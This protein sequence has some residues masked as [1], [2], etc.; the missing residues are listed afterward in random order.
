MP[1]RRQ[2]EQ[3]LIQRA[4]NPVQHPQGNGQRH[5]YQQTGQ[6]PSTDGTHHEDFE[7]VSPLEVLLLAGAAGAA[8][9][10]AA[11]GVLAAED[12]ATPVC[13]G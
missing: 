13:P 8:T 12:A 2:D 6:Q 3:G 4:D 9:G 11:A 7:D 1:G 10:A 5:Q